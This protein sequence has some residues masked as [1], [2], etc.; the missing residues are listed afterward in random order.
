M[1]K[2]LTDEDGQQ[3][4]SDDGGTSD[5]TLLRFESVSYASGSEEDECDDTSDLSCQSC[6]LG[7]LVFAEGSEAS[8]DD[9]EDG[10]CVP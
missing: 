1:C 8:K 10:V 9:E 7:V 6:M 4:P 3:F 5:I 2:S